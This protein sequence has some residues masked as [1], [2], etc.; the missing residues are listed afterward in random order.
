MNSKVYKVHTDTFG[1]LVACI[2]KGMYGISSSAFTK[3]L[4]SEFNEVK[5]GDIVFISEREVSNN[6]LFG[7]FYV[8]K[9]RPGIAYKSRKGTWVEIDTKKT[10]PEEIAYWVELEKRN[11]CLLFDKILSERISIVWPYNWNTLNVNLPSWGLIKEED[12]GKLV[13]FSL[14]NEIEAREFFKRHNVW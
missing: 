4:P 6:A 5:P 10:P 14:K 1:R 8:V 7:P 11:W 3:K 13:D 2:Q 12:A 9:E